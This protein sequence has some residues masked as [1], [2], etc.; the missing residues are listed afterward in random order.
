MGLPR[1]VILIALAGVT[2]CESC[3]SEDLVDAPGPASYTVSASWRVTDLADAELACDQVDGRF[4]SVTF[5]HIATGRLFTDAF[6]CFRK[7]G[8]RSLEE[9]EYMIGFELTDQLGPLVAVAPRRY[10]IDGDTTLDEVKFQL[11]PFGDLV[12]TL[13]TPLPT[14][15]SG[16]S[17]ITGMSIEMYRSNGTCQ[18]STLAIEPAT[19][20]AINCTAPMITGCIE[21]DRRV[22][23]AH[24]PAGEYRIRVVAQQGATPCWL[25]DQRHR[26]RAAGLRRTV[27]LPLTKT[28]N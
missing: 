19:T 17:Q 13:E 4:V 11:D 28:C 18:T 3:G 27:A 25:H 24:F 15:C 10:M 7:T 9:G 16:G 5:F 14:N 6:N 21:K 22:T 26:I 12:M 2:G 23:A 1:A 8:T 20:Y